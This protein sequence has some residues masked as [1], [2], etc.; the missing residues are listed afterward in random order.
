MRR[1]EN[2]VK[3]VLS[4]TSARGDVDKSGRCPNWRDVSC[5]LRRDGGRRV[6]E[7]AVT[8]DGRWLR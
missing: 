8:F 5:I 2:G 7:E 4:A 3:S 6:E 1:R